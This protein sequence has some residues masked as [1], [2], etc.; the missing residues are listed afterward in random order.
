M[1]KNE[2]CI[3]KEPLD[4]IKD[5]FYMRFEGKCYEFCERCLK[6]HVIKCDDVG[7]WLVTVIV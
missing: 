1:F 5:Y 7:K 4:H 2:C 6:E 3:C